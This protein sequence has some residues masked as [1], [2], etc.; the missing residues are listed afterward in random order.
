MD[1][2]SQQTPQSRSIIMPEK[3]QLQTLTIAICTYNRASLLQ[4]MIRSLLAQSDLDFYT[5]ILDD[6]STDSTEEICRSHES[7]TFRYIRNETNIGFN[8]NYNK[9]I[10]TA[11]TTH[12]L[13]THDDDFMDPHFI[14]NLKKGIAKHPDAIMISSNVRLVDENGTVIKPNALGLESDLVL[15]KGSYAK[16]FFEDNLGLYC[17]TYC[18][19]KELIESSGI[20]FQ[21][22]G[23]GSDLLISL[24]TNRFGNIVVLSE[25]QFNVCSHPNQ[26]HAQVV[27]SF[28][29][30]F[31]FAQVATPLVLSEPLYSEQTDRAI[32]YLMYYFGKKLVSLS[33]AEKDT[34]SP[35]PQD[36]LNFVNTL[37][38]QIRDIALSCSRNRLFLRLA[39]PSAKELQLPVIN[40]D[41][42]GHKLAGTDTHKRKWHLHNLQAYDRL[43]SK[44]SHPSWIERFP[45]QLFKNK[46]VILWGLSHTALLIILLLRAI[47][48]KPMQVIDVNPKFEYWNILG[49]TC[50]QFETI[51]SSLKST[52]KD[53]LIVT[54]TEGAQEV[55]VQLTLL[56]NE[57]DSTKAQVITWREIAAHIEI[58]TK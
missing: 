26:D 58:S 19:K 1:A 16:S 55:D 40:A 15:E 13:I 8:G 32:F 37:P 3:D 24:E 5:C 57:F 23:P 35:S 41:S 14:S 45:E 10:E 46:Q 42:W 54:C 20:Q 44:L 28:N 21:S 18:F 33:I 7:D 34:L 43:D 51:A 53:I 27:K 11:K 6:C 39:D 50:S 25:V 48:M 36:L 29:A 4:K 47:G 12:V 9:A 31:D 49:I 17:P 22:V 2:Y 52:S 38:A 30:G 56:E